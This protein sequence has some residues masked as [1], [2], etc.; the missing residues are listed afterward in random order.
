MAAQVRAM[1]P[2]FWGIWGST[3]TMFKVGI[4]GII[5]LT[6]G[7][8]VKNKNNCRGKNFASRF[9]LCRETDTGGELPHIRHATIVTYSI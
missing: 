3:K 1:L 2:V 7:S 9:P 8:P 4:G 6:A 5:I